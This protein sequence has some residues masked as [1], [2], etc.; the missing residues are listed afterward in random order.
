MNNIEELLKKMKE[1]GGSMVN[2]SLLDSSERIALEEKINQEIHNGNKDFYM[3]IPYLETFNIGEL[4]TQG[5]REKLDDENWYLLVTQI[6][7]RSPSRGLLNSIAENAKSNYFALK[8]LEEIAS[9]RPDIVE[10]PLLIDSI[11]KQ[12]PSVLTKP[13][14]TQ[15][16][17]KKTIYFKLTSGVVLKIIPEDFTAYRFNNELLEWQEDS[18][19]F[20]EYEH[21]NLEGERF[22][23]TENY[24][25]GEP[26]HFGRRL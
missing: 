1:N 19:L 23:I 15:G 26:F 17:K 10:L 5:N 9:K 11:K 22:N 2:L 13:E 4:L 20:T 7:L 24:P 21:G 6:Y 8:S 14:I 3:Y 25:I 16:P 12:N 18:V